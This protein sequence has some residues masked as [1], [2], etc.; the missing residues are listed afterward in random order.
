MAINFYYVSFAEY[1][2]KSSLCFAIG[3]NDKLPDA[4]R[5]LHIGAAWASVARC[6]NAGPMPGS[7]PIINSGPS[8][9]IHRLEHTLTACVIKV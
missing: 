8:T 9:D 6:L 3:Y 7:E 1:L 4:A 5:W 2:R